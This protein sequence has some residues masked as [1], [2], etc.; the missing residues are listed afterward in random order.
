MKIGMPNVA[1]LHFSM[2]RR[3]ACHIPSTSF[4][5]ATRQRSARSTQ[6]GIRD[7]GRCTED[8]VQSPGDT[9]VK[10]IMRAQDP[11]FREVPSETIRGET[12]FD[13]V[14]M[15]N[16]MN[17]AMGSDDGARS[18]QCPSCERLI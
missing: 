4:A 17:D 9:F 2:H 5:A 6:V 18:F 15:L 7:V 8:E 13:P 16:A 3:I 10:A 11:I 14:S 1:G 12:F